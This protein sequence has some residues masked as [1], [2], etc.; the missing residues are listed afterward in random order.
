MWILPTVYSAY[1][2]D[3]KKGGKT[4]QQMLKMYQ[5]HNNMPLLMIASVPFLISNGN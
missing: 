1:T 5:E 3:P 4:C 2:M